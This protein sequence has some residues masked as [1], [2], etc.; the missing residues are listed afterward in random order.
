MLLTIC[1]GIYI[2]S[3][4]HKMLHFWTN[5]CAVYVCHRWIWWVFPLNAMTFVSFYVEAVHP[6]TYCTLMHNMSPMQG[7]VLVQFQISF[8]IPASANRKFILISLMADM[9]QIEFHTLFSFFMLPSFFNCYLFQITTMPLESLIRP[10][11]PS[12]IPTFLKAN[13]RVLC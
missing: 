10:S 6:L 7:V 4:N 2:W 9:Q 8:A 11:F 3:S 13:S 5:I 1:K 12:T